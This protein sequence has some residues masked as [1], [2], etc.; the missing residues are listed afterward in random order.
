MMRLWLDP[1]AWTILI[2][3]TISWPVGIKERKSSGM[4]RITLDFGARNRFVDVVHNYH[5]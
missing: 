5:S 2:L 4:K 3:I 1:F